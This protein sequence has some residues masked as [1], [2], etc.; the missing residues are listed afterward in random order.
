MPSADSARRPL[1]PRR[2]PVAA[3][4]PGSPAG[5]P[6]PSTSAV[7]PT[8]RPPAKR[9]DARPM[10]VVYGAASVA[11]LSALTVGL[12]H[13]SAPVEEE[14]AF[15]TTADVASAPPETTVTSAPIEVTHVINYVHLQPGE[16]PPPGATVIAPDAPAPRIVV[17][18][19]PGKVIRQPAPAAASSSSSTTTS[20]PKKR[21]RT[22]QSGTP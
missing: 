7:H 19:I 15:D 11:A 1:P 4:G 22:R 16:T 3:T 18:T 6:A 5:S 10:R 9:P 14:V 8:A 21:V 13:P 12:A 17:T 20:Q 2:E